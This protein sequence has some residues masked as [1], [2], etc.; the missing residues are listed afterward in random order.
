M[1]TNSH[2]HAAFERVITSS[3]DG[4][5]A[6]DD[7]F[8]ITVWNPGMEFITGVTREDAVDRQLLEVFPRLKETGD[9][10]SLQEALAGETTIAKE[11]TYALGDG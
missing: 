4:I 5:F 3:I 10:D 9:Y 7:S 2:T 6:C 11:S 1:E 8:N